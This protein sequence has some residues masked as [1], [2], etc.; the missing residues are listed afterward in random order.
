MQWVLL[1]TV[2]AYLAEDSLLLPLAAKMS[3]VRT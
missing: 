1:S 2:D 3:G